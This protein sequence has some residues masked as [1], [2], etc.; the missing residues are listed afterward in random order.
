M[1]HDNTSSPT[2]L[3][4]QNSRFVPLNLAL[5]EASG[6]ERHGQILSTGDGSELGMQLGWKLHLEHGVI[7]FGRAHG[8][9]DSIMLRC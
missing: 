3:F 9:S 5:E 7:F 2:L 1:R 8:S 6:N 4:L